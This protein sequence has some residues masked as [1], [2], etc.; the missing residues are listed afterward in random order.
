MDYKIMYEQ[1]IKRAKAMIQVAANQEEIY[2]SV[3]TIFPELKESEDDKIRKRIIHALHG[4]VLEM[5]EIKE[6]IDWLEKQGEQ[7]LVED[8]NSDDYGIDSLWHAHRI[9]EKTLG[10]VE[11]YQSDDGILE[12]E[13]AISAVKKLYEQKPAWSEEDDRMM[14][15]T[16]A[17]VDWYAGK[18]RNISV[19]V[20]N[21]LKLLKSRV[22]SSSLREFDKEEGNVIDHLIAICDD[23][24]CY[25]TFAGCSKKDIEKYKSFLTNLKF[26]INPQPQT[27]WKPSDEQMDSI[28]CAV[29]K[30]K[31]SACYDSELVSLFNDL[32]K[33]KA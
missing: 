2:N 15:D 23:A 10:K 32:K 6:A 24:M 31:E 28:D 16:L 5:S 9:L 30:M 33:L 1:A 21:W 11:G 4:D 7:N 14:N 3:I 29:R 17:V 25:D 18:H 22:L 8:V 13:C 12:H 19:K 26:G 27:A 20:S